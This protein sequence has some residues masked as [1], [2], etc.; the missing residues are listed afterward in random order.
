MMTDSVAGVPVAGV[1]LLAELVGAAV[2][3]GSVGEAE[4]DSVEGT[5]ETDVAVSSLEQPAMPSI[6]LNT[7]DETNKGRWIIFMPL[8]CHIAMCR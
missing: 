2:L 1:S 7:I 3:T 4:V 5:C 6:P 8:S